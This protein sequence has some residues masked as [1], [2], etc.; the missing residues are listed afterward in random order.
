MKRAIR[1]I[2]FLVTLFFVL[3]TLLLSACFNPWAG[4]ADAGKGTI[5]LNFGG[6]SNQARVT[7]SMG[8]IQYTVTVYE[9]LDPLGTATPGA[10]VHESSFSSS[11]GTTSINVNPGDYLIEVK[12]SLNG[13]TYADNITP[14]ATLSAVSVVAGAASAATVTMT[15]TLNVGAYLDAMGSGS[16]PTTPI[17]LP[18]ASIPK[19]TELLTALETRTVYVN[20]DLS[21]A[22]GNTFVMP[23]GFT[24]SRGRIVSIILPN[25]AETI[26]ETISPPAFQNFT[27]LTSVSG[28]GVTTIQSYA[29]MG[30]STLT[31][32]SFPKL[33]TIANGAV[34]EG[35]GLTSIDFP[36]LKT[37]GSTAF[38]GVTSFS[39]VTLPKVET[40]GLSAFNNCN[41]TGPLD[42]PEVKDIDNS[43]FSSNNIT[44]I[45][46]PK[47]VSIGVEAFAG[48][49]DLASITI[50][51]GATLNETI[52]DTITPYGRFVTFYNNPAGSDKAVGRY[53][54]NGTTWTYLGP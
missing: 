5:I 35:T 17:N 11:G 50:S 21:A 28:S 2:T 31:S 26:V 4:S 43:A 16:T 7:P 33:E 40:I 45:Y 3:C 38:N 32:A 53:T 13:H 42:L 51:G 14:P 52:P 49:P 6:S 54:Y 15:M 23:V 12:A 36:E 48:N 20:V 47:V 27:I 18:L 46:I 9:N 34:F 30:L 22:S 8:M 41:I 24:T 39:S 1:S 19:F 29:F 37:I 10:T 25:T 44:S